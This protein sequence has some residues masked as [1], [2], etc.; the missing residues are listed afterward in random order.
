MDGDPSTYFKS[1][2][3]MSDG[4]D[5]TIWLSRAIP[6]TSFRVV[7]GNTDNEDLLTKGFVELSADGEKFTRSAAF[8]A[9]GVSEATLANVPVRALRIKLNPRTGLS[10]LCI[11]E[12]TINSPI[13]I[14]HA[15]MGPGRGW[16]DY[17]DAPDLAAW[18][19]K[20]ERQMEDFWPDTAALLYT[21]GFIT[22]NKLNVVYR[23]G[24]DVTP[25]AATG[26]GV[27]TVNIKWARE[28]PGD[29]GLTVHEMAHAVQSMSAYNPVW[30]IE[31]IADYIRWVRYEPQNFTYGIT[32]KNEW[33]Q[34]YRVSAA[35]LGWC[36]IH[37]DNRL[38]THLN[39]DI[40]FGRYKDDLWKKYTGKD[41]DTLWAEFI[42][43]YNADPKGVLVPPIA[44]ADRP[45]MLPTVQAG[46]SA[47]ASLAGLFT[48]S[49]FYR[50]GARFGGNV[51][52]DEGGAA[53]PAA[54]LG[55]SVTWKNVR[56]DLGKADQANVVASRGQ[57]VALKEGKYGSL[58]LLA[59]AVEG[60]QMA[61]DFV[62]NY[63]DGSQ[64]SF[65]QNVS[66]WYSPGGFP[67]ES[68]AVK[69][70]YRVLGDGTKDPRPFYAYSYGF[71]LDK[72]K[73]VASV[74]LPN[75][76]NVKVLAVTVAN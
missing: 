73:E 74:V 36:E 4:D 48:T 10:S 18:A 54:T 1:Y 44:P 69:F 67:G 17:T 7:T 16:H 45:R 33:R 37:Y 19:T 26:G 56:F 20:A 8:N 75:N 39:D 64:Q 21:N 2:Y 3:N 13:K 60:N 27:M 24:P 46:T 68:R 52:F 25:V 70:E 32:N 66:D 65:A 51:G 63:K 12:I 47:P 6:A 22:P 53:F 57:K 30:L 11:R 49:G 14:S 15:Q 40:R 61:Q 58:W 71:A 41:G 29:T 50:D 5:V 31:G 62:V 23:G 35:F 34:P 59:A 76:P 28:N 9:Q 38:V 42:A 43:A 55:T 72:N